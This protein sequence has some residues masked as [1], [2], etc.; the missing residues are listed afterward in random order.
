MFL[1][2][3]P[4]RPILCALM[5]TSGPTVGNTAGVHWRQIE[6][7]RPLVAAH[8]RPG[9]EASAE[10]V[11]AFQRDGVVLLPGVF[12]E[13][14]EPLRTGLQRILD[15][16]KRHA[17]P[18]DST[19]AG[20]PGRFFDA[21]CNW[22]IVPEFLDFVMTSSSAAMAAAFMQSSRAQLFHEHAFSKE[23]AT[24]KATPWHHDLPYYCIDGDQTVSVYVALDDTPADTAVQFVKGSHRTGE[25]FYPR[26][27][28]AGEDYVSSDPRMVSAPEI[29]G[30]DD[31]IFRSA[32]TAGDAVLFDFRTLHGTTDA[33]VSMR[34][35]A[36]S[37][38]WLG[39]DVRYV[40]RPGETSPPLTDLG[41]QPGDRM[42]DDWFPILWS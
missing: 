24:A 14:V 35:R 33:L 23:A 38:R 6:D 30:D 29:D 41:L 18:C 1:R 3:P 26:N 39:D 27:F 10:D 9:F 31:R 40:E 11:D 17:F 37:T 22:Q 25:L 16:P 8:Q 13:W 2:L 5:T 15:A 4:A 7:V 19:V 32:L 42:R 12:R 36:F 21:Y 28:R 34:R 20:E